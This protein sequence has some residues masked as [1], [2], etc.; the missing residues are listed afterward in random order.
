MRVRITGRLASMAAAVFTAA[1]IT[2]ASP[3]L[4]N[5]D[6]GKPGGPVKLV[7]AYQP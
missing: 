7:V 4:A 1:A 3:A 5:E 2:V 6:Y